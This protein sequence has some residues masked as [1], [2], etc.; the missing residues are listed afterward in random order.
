M[1]ANM[2]QKIL[3]GA[4]VCALSSST[5]LA[6]IA[7]NFPSNLSGNQPGGPLA[8][9]SLFTVSQPVEV[10]SLGVFDSGGDGIGG[11][12]VSVAIYS[13][14]L[15]GGSITAGQL[16]VSPYNFSGTADALLD[17]SSTRFHDISPVTLSSGTYLVVANHYGNVNS[18]ERN[19]NYFV[20]PNKVVVP[21]ANDQANYV[22]FG[23]SYYLSADAASWGE[24]LPT[25]W[26]L[27]SSDYIPQYAAGNFDF[28]PVPEASSFAIAGVG[29]LGLVY[30]GRCVVQRRK[31]VA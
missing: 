28:T 15:S 20:D 21:T 19:Y 7:Y 2:T 27:G 30:V 18:S 25:G 12:G 10:N 16:V 14:T 3:A 8:L 9:G 29:L 6:T 4:A 31:A 13:V 26:S 1:K 22:A 24:A 23:R 5:L 17:G 11:A